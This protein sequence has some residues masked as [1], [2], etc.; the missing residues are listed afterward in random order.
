MDVEGK[1]HKLLGAEAIL[2]FVITDSPNGIPSDL[3]YTAKSLMV[4]R[5]THNQTNLHC[6]ATYPVAL[7]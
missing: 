2:L 6:V 1:P 5:K 3:D 7:L 4:G